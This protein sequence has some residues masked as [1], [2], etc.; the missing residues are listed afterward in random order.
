MTVLMVHLVKILRVLN[1]HVDEVAKPLFVVYEKP[2]EV[3][4]AK[5]KFNPNI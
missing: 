4:T 2:S 1:D 3:T 5:G